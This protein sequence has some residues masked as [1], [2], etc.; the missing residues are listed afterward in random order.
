M[1]SQFIHNQNSDAF[2]KAITAL[3][4]RG[5]EEACMMVVDGEPGLGKS[6]F[7]KWWAINT[8]SIYLRAR[9]EWTPAWMMR[10]I[11]EFLGLKPPHSFEDM[12]KLVKR[13][14]TN[15]MDEA[16]EQNRSFA[17]VIDEMDH[18][19]RKGRLLETLRDLSDDVEVPLILIGM[20][21]IKHNIVR[22]PQIASRVCQFVSFNPISLDE[23]I[24]LSQKSQSI[25]IDPLLLEYLHIASKGH[26][27]EIKEGLKAIERLAHRNAL[28]EVTI[29]H[30]MGQT[31]F[32][33]RSTGKPIIIKPSD[34]KDL[35]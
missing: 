24:K 20:G 14:V 4:N 28:S 30:M 31:L 7:A 10:D 9:K 22:F 19:S 29:S 13:A 35:A 32:N 5:A 12:F 21:K 23:T 16:E 25:T 17:I 27:R 26:L 6:A 11:L 8:Q 3:E 18:I 15:L 33:S 2:L 1:I 34:S